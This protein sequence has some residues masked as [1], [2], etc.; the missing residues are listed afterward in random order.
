MSC[1]DIKI[2]S[3]DLL[4][5]TSVTSFQVERK[6][7]TSV[8]PLSDHPLAPPCTAST[9]LRSAQAPH[10]QAAQ[11]LST[12]CLEMRRLRAR[13]CHAVSAQA[14]TSQSRVPLLLLT[15]GHSTRLRGAENTQPAKWHRLPVPYQ[16]KCVGPR[17][18]QTS[19]RGWSGSEV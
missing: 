2:M 14:S 18:L 16:R 9:M 12:C 6:L 3:D 8:L 1:N 7:I 15:E 5:L 4:G 13:G 19:G 10:L 11:T 17:V